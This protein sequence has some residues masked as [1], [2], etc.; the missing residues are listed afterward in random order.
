MNIRTLKNPNIV[1]I[2]II[3]ATALITLLFISLPL[4][5]IIRYLS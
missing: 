2:N 5:I 1:A 3:I 4:K